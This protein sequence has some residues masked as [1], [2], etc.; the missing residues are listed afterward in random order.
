MKR[1]SYYK[2]AF[3]SKSES[4]EL[5]QMLTQFQNGIFKHSIDTLRMHYEN[6]NQEYSKAKSQLPAVTFSALFGSK[7][8][9]EFLEHYTGILVFDID[10]L[11]TEN[12]KSLLQQ[13]RKDDLISCA[14]ISPSNRGIKFI[15]LTEASLVEH[16][17]F[18]YALL[19][20]FESKY[21]IK[22][23]KSGSDITRLC[24]V[25]YDNSLEIKT[26]QNVIKREFIDEIATVEEYRIT[27]HTITSDKKNSN[28]SGFSNDHKK[29]KGKNLAQHRETMK[30]IIEYLDSQNKSIT[31]T[32]ENWYRVAYAIANS[33]SYDVG[34]RYYLQLCRMDKNLHFEEKSIKMLRYCYENK[35]NNLINFSTLIY[36]AQKEGFDLKKTSNRNSVFKSLS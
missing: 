13:L 21:N 4:I 30:K 1:I 16:K 23:D 36:L 33:F 22:I 14:W 35:I 25:S 17:L 10:K 2:N 8:K 6:S 3:E 28:S 15:V 18:F 31:N 19:E 26:N 29:G 27:I 11:E 12:M 7:R 32:Y 34:E 5:H 20:L 24:Y 9:L